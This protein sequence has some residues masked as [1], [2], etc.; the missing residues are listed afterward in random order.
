MP[1]NQLINIQNMS[2]KFLEVYY[3]FEI[4]NNDYLFFKAIK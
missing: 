3:D 1:L 2:K 4:I